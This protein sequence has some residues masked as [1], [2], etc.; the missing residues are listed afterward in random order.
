MRPWRAAATLPE[1]WAIDLPGP[2]RTGALCAGR[3]ADEHRTVGQ[4]RLRFARVNR[5]ACVVRAAHGDGAGSGELGRQSCNTSAGSS[6]LC[7]G[8]VV[9]PVKFA[10]SL[11][12][13]RPTVRTLTRSRSQQHRPPQTAFSVAVEGMGET[14]TCSS[15]S[16]GRDSLVV[17]LLRDCPDRCLGHFFLVGC[18]ARLVPR[19]SL[20]P[21]LC[22]E[23]LVRSGGRPVTEPTCRACY[24]ESPAAEFRQNYF[25]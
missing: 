25:P 10:L 18:L 15:V 14:Q 7:E 1:P 4:N 9:P 23:P 5:G 21:V 24:T 19:W 12:I 17:V 6:Q 20:G 3:Q 11:S 22:N 13:R 2:A 16:K 8:F